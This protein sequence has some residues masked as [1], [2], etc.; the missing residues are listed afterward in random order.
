MGEVRQT[1]IV[2]GGVFS[3]FS[4]PYHSGVAEEEGE[5][6]G[7]WGEFEEWRENII[8]IILNYYL[9]L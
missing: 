1:E 2:S 9:G 5:V 6:G 8:I 4:I 7:V 3:V